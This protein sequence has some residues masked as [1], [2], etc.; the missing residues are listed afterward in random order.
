MEMIFLLLGNLKIIFRQIENVQKGLGVLKEDLR[1]LVCFHAHSLFEDL[2]PGISKTVRVTVLFNFNRISGFEPPPARVF[3]WRVLELKDQGVC[4]EE[5]M[6][7]A[8]VRISISL[9]FITEFSLY[10]T[11]PQVE[12]II[13][14][15]SR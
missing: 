15:R 13:I 7:V 11:R 12:T 9:H 2:F 3:A 14:K 10:D 8:D 5:A 6:A 1:T 4:E